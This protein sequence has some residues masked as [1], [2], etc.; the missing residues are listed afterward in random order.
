VGGAALSKKFADTRIAGE[1][2]GPVLYAKDAMN[3]LDLANQLCEPSQRAELLRELAERQEQAGSATA[4][5]AP[6]EPGPD[7][8][9]R[10]AVRPDA[11]ILN[12]PDFQQ[13]ILRDIP[14]PR[15]IPYLNRQMLYSKHLGLMGVLDKLLEAGEEKA[16]K[17][18][19]SVNR[20]LEKIERNQL[21]RPQALYRFYPA[22]GEGND[23]I[24]FDPEGSGREIM[25][26]S[27]PRQ[28]GGER[29]CLADFA[30]PVGSGEMDSVALFTVTC[31]IGVRAEAERL[32]EAG[33][34]LECHLLQALALELAEATAEFL[35]QRLRDAWGI[36]DDPSLTMKGILNADYQGI[37][38]S[39]G[40]P[41]CPELADQ[42]KLFDLLSPSQIGVEL[43]EGYMMDPE[44]SVSALAFHHPEGRYFSVVR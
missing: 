25:R 15:I 43:T 28:A 17:L 33:E 7:A 26:F 10:S 42:Q 36:V 23:L 11:P 41:A 5:K 31:G 35:H 22:L 29:L 9:L 16:L 44:A 2:R 19:A 13:H 21:I 20:M 34:Y 40:Y 39:F 4:R 37:R 38:V 12:P 27:F 3:G 30:R 24:L 14:I 1:Y 18:H 6:Q 8:T 32:K